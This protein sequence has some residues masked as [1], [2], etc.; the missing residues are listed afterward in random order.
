[1]AYSS[2]LAIPFYDLSFFFTLTF[3][4]SGTTKKI[5]EC[6]FFRHIG[7]LSFS[8]YLSH[9]VILFKLKHLGFREE[10]L[11]FAV[12]IASYIVSLASYILVEKPLLILKKKLAV[13]KKCYPENQNGKKTPNKGIL[14]PS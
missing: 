12:L 7:L 2:Y 1:M 3:Y 6:Y 8:I 5:L 9:M 11:F 13:R 14:V 4:Q 10:G